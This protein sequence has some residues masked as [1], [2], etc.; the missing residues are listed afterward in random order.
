M[1]AAMYDY[2]RENLNKF[3]WGG[4]DNDTFAE[5]LTE[6]RARKAQA[7]KT[8]TAVTS[9][10]YSQPKNTKRVRQFTVV[11][12][13]YNPRT[14]G[15]IADLTEITN[16]LARYKSFT[17]WAWAIHDSDVYTQDAIDDMNATLRNEAKKIHGLTDEAA[18]AQYVG[19]NIWAK[20]G[21]KKGVHLHIVC[22]M[23]SALE[24][25][26]IAEWLGVP[27]HLVEVVKGKG[28]LLDCT[29]YLTHED[30]KQQQLGKT[31]YDDSAVH[32]SDSFSDWR[33]QLDARKVQEAKYGK[34][35]SRVEKYIIDV[36]KYGKTMRECRAEMDGNDYVNNL[37]KL[38]KAR[39][40]YLS[41]AKL[42]ESRITF[43]VDGK[44][45]IG[46][47]IL[48]ELL[49]RA[50]CSD[51]AQIQDIAFTVG[52]ENVAFDD[53]D[54]QPV[55]IW[56][57]VRAVD[58]M[59]MLGRRN[60]LHALAPHPRETEESSVSIKYGKTRLLHKFNI[61]NG[62]DPYQQFIHNLAG[63]YTDKKGMKHHAE[64]NNLE[65]F[66]RRFPIIIPIRESDFDILINQGVFTGTREYEQYISYASM[67][68]SFAHLQTMCGN[69]KGLLIDMSKPMVDPIVEVSDH[70]QER[71]ATSQMTEEQIKAEAAKLG[72]GTR[73]NGDG[74][75]D[76]KTQREYDE[77]VERWK[78][79][80]PEKSTSCVMSLKEWILAGRHTHWD[81]KRKCWY[82]PDDVDGN[83]QMSF[84]E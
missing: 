62:V 7:K 3:G 55:L 60:V 72:Y 68:G 15:F 22:Q 58:M 42:P 21:D 61:I 59:M 51:I 26:K 28:A 37:G 18:I 4:V 14:G 69:N 44:G 30:E 82:R 75:T 77:F 74:T 6:Q 64:V 73:V 35:K 16:N 29:E 84:F 5:F 48:C 78:K 25:W 50:L 19:N 8:A 39:G 81:K 38:Q 54:G 70:L 46:K 10:F 32:A 71:F 2:I 47:G 27:E 79:V 66:Y 63:E 11:Q 12:F 9:S 65:Q 76:E 80:N 40:E 53:Y 13:N 67:I 23:N 31:L 52:G 33:Q 45:G 34:G 56:D 17:Y 1:D 57:D 36:L 83:H 49:A 43:Y 20:L 24:I 41:H